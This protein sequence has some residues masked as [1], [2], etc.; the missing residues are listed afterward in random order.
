MEADQPLVTFHFAG[1]PGETVRTLAEVPAGRIVGKP[2]YVLTS[3]GTGSAAEEF[4]G[5]V[6]GY[7]LGEVVGDTTGGAG[8]RNELVPVDGGFVL[9]VS[10]GRA[11]L[12]ST[13]RD[14]EAVGIAPTMRTDV[15]AALDVAQ[16][17]AL[18]R[19]AASAPA[20]QRARLEAIADTLAAAAERRPAALPLA[21]YAGSYGERRVVAEDGRL[22]YRLGERAPIALVALG[23][24]RFT[25]ADDPGTQ[26]QF[27]ANGDIVSALEMGPVGGPVQGRYE[28]TR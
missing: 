10:V 27:A 19:I 3:D 22:V 8:F 7:R 16:S 17:A 21:A 6:A 2:L 25:F 1:R 26:L 4:V 24:N 14:W 18:R 9:S 23:G 20:G 12:A 15:A 28:R 11:V 5:H 13:G